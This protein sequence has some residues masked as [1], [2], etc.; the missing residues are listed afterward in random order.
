MSDTP[1]VYELVAL[2]EDAYNT[3]GGYPIPY[4][5]GYYSTMKNAEEAWTRYGK[6]HNTSNVKSESSNK[7]GYEIYEIIA[8]DIDCFC[9]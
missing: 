9:S 3:N 5:L 8:D 1:V 6:S 2:D 4:H 7:I